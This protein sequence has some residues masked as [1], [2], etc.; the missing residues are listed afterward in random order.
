MAQVAPSV[1]IALTVVFVLVAVFALL[2]VGL[3]FF[4]SLGASMRAQLAADEEAEL[5]RQ[6]PVVVDEEED[7]ASEAGRV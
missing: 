5:A 1:G 3:F 7:Q 2:G 6:Q 4:E